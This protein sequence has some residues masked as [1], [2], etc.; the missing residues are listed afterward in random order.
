MKKSLLLLVFLIV[1]TCVANKITKKA[2]ETSNLQELIED[3]KQ[4]KTTN[5]RF[6]MGDVWEHSCW[7][8]IAINNWF[9]EGKEWTIGLNKH[10]RELAILAGLLHDVGKAGD[11]NFVFHTKESHASIGQEYVQGSRPYF[12][13]THKLFNFKKFFDS[14]SLSSVDRK[15]I[16]ILIGAHHAFGELLSCI[17]HKN[18]LTIDDEKVSKCCNTFMQKVGQCIICAHYPYPITTKLIRLVLLICVA[19]VKGAQR[20]EGSCLCPQFDITI[21][22]SPV[23]VHTEATDKFEE[24]G[25]TTRGRYY[26]QI[27]LDLPSLRPYLFNNFFNKCSC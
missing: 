7:V 27:L 14:I 25:Y 19:D 18:L 13:S 15:I 16:A 26:A 8:A 22:K 10:D 21:K 6:H 23:A 24:F 4:Y 2:L 9:K 12:L 5:G 11:M 20:V 1:S 3:F 17:N